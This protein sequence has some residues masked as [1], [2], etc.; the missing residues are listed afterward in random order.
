MSEQDENLTEQL[1]PAEKDE[2]AEI[3]LDFEA[4]LRNPQGRRVLLWVLQQC[5]VYGAIYTGK[6]AGTNLNL[7]E[8]NVGLR[9][10]SKLDEVGP[11]EYPRLLLHAAQQADLDPKRQET[12][13]LD[14]PDI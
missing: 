14:E 2:R 1:L 8:R 4:V 12:H 10:I 13:V 9:I 11:T 7:G 6:E 5:H 3:L